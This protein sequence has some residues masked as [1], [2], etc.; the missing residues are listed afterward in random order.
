MIAHGV[1]N[2]FDFNNQIALKAAEIDDKRSDRVL[3][4]KLQAEGTLP[5]HAG[6]V[7][8]RPL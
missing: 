5:E 1:D 2:P 4:A 7:H 8:Q 6:A 3:A